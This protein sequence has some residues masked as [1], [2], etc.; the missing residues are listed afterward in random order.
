MAKREA[1]QGERRMGTILAFRRS[2]E[3]AIPVGKPVGGSLGEIIIFP[4][5]RI[6][7][8][9]WTEK[10]AETRAP[11]RRRAQRARKK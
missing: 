11:S 5:V 3:A 10:P 6:E 7:R 1:L 9:V 4:G 8:G 2:D